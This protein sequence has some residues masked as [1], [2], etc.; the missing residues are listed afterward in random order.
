MTGI[1]RMIC[2][3]AA[4]LA[5]AAC[6]PVGP[7][8]GSGGGDTGAGGGAAGGPVV[9]ESGAERFVVALGQIGVNCPDGA[10]SAADCAGTKLRAKVT[11][12]GAAFAG[13]EDERASV[14]VAIGKACEARG[15][16]SGRFTLTDGNYQSGI[17]VFDDAC[18]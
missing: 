10:V 2:A 14:R 12:Q 7:G 17:W 6:E 1:G 8:G 4:A 5:L 16:S 18:I 11:R 13:T 9:I 3:G 15:Q